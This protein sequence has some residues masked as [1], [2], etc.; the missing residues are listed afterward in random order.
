MRELNKHQ[1][2]F[3]SIE[4]IF[5]ARD[6]LNSEKR[7]KCDCS[8]LICATPIWWGIQSSIMQRAIERID[9]LDEE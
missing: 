1:K 4:D 2:N 6:L 8:I 3:P 7:R 5:R 9:T